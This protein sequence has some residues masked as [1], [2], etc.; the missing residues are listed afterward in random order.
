MPPSPAQHWTVPVAAATVERHPFAHVLRTVGRGPTLS[1]PLTLEE[2][3]AAMAL[4]LDGR[5]EPMQIG[6]F[7]LLLRYRGETA[8]EL[9]GFTRAARARLANGAT[10]RV[11]LDWPS[12]ADAHKQLPYFVL[13]ALLL[14]GNGV[15]V[16]MHGLAG[17][18]AGTTRHGLAALGLA[19]ARSAAEAAASLEATGFAYLPVETMLPALARLLDL[20]PVLGLRS[21]A[22]TM[23]RELNP[24]HAPCMIQGVFHPPYLELHRGTQ[25][26]LGQPRAVTFKG[27][28]G[29]GQRHPEKACRVLELAGGEERTATW[30]ALAPGVGYPWRDEPLRPER[31]LA[32]W[33]GE[34]EVPALAAAVTGTAA[35]ALKLLGRA[36]EPDEAQALAEA[37]W[38]VRDRDR[39]GGTGGDGGRAV[40]A[41]SAR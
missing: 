4:I 37:M 6:A 34:I 41:G 8:E 12:Y 32:L 9:A 25:R 38:R 19:P 5:A 23:A 7:L 11:D 1:R 20:K 31:L 35:I 39:P 10:A 26:L 17:V 29:E 24:F 3:E 15:R 28:G 36:G 30:P 22:N 27:G 16:L 40:L 18:G 13:A 21:F 14:A 33:R 2:A